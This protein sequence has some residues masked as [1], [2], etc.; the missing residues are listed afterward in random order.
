MEVQCYQASDFCFCVHTNTGKPFL[1]GIYE[2]YPN[3]PKC[4]KK[5]ELI[6]KETCGI[7]KKNSFKRYLR[8]QFKKDHESLFKNETT[9]TNTIL[10]WKY[11]M[12]DEDKNTLVEPHEWSSFG[13]E[14]LKFLR[15]NSITY[16][17]CAKR[18]I[19]LDCDKDKNEIVTINEFKE[20]F[21]VES[22]KNRKKKNK[23]TSIS[24]PS[25]SSLSSSSSPTLLK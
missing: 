17:E 19:N 9:P 12:I 24:S 1:P 4:S 13:K 11:T 15:K 10:R 6:R 14:T 21:K 2:R 18:L 23:S 8:N 3:K 7:K 22:R 20:C 5:T 16:I 25:S